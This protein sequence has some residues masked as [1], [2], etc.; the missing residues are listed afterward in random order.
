MNM[1]KSHIQNA[2]KLD[3]NIFELPDKIG[4]ENVL[5][6]LALGA[7]TMNGLEDEMPDRQRNDCFLNAVYSG[8]H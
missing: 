2:H 4:R 7:I 5:P 6:A 8:Y 3:F 1:F